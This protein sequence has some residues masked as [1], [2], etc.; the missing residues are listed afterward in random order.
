MQFTSAYDRYGGLEMYGANYS[1]TLI[2]IPKRICVFF[3]KSIDHIKS[4]KT[5]LLHTLSSLTDEMLTEL[6]TTTVGG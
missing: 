3:E 1:L 4:I 6:V 2:Y 5:H